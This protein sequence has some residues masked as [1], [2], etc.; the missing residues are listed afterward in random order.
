[1]LGPAENAENF[2]HKMRG[3]IP[4]SFETLFNLINNEKELVSRS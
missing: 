4:R 3:V 1:M 2:Q